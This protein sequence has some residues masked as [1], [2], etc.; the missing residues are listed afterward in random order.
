MF[1]KT[2]FH[3]TKRIRELDSGILMGPLQFEISCDCVFCHYPF[4]L[5]A[6]RMLGKGLE[7]FTLLHWFVL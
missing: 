1:K 4:S 3:Y 7:D 5:V 2:H 6:V